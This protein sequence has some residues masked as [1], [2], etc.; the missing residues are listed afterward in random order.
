MHLHWSGTTYSADTEPMDG[1]TCSENELMFMMGD[2]GE[3]V[4]RKLELKP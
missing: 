3:K 4:K 1:E 2:F